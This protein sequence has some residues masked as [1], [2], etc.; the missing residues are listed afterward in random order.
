MTANERQQ[1]TKELVERCRNDLA[2][3]AKATEELEAREA[4][5]A[6]ILTVHWLIL[7]ELVRQIELRLDLVTN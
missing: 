2:V 7:A 1:V 6:A 3:L 5:E 4:N